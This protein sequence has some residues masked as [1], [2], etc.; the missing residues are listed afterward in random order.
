MGDIIA[1]EGSPLSVAV[2]GVADMEASLHF[3]RDLI[4]LTAHDKV[5]WSG[6]AFET[7]WQLPAGSSAEAVF[8]ELPN[9]PVGRVLLLDFNAETRE[10]IR[11][12]E[13]ARAYGLVNLNFYTTTSLVIPSY[14]KA[15]AT[16]SG[17]SRLAMKCRR[18]RV[19]PS[20]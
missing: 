14:S 13:T 19:P 1:P 4:G 15:T 3:Y 10:E 6:S 7:L 9:Y 20:R 8:C 2:I 18:R 11:G 16:S 17:L 5:T 12:E